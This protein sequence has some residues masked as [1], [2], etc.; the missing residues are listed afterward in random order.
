MAFSMEVV[1][2]ADVKK[3]VAEEVKP[4]PAEKTQL[5]KQAEDNAL[6][7]M[8]IDLDSLEDKKNIIQSVETFGADSVQRSAEKNNLLKTTVGQLSNAGEEG[9]VVSKGLTD[10]HHEIESLDPSAVD[11]TKTGFLGKLFNPVRGYFE[12]YEKAEDVIAN[13]MDSLDKGRATLKNDNTTLELEEQD[14]REITKKLAKGIEM[15]TMMDE[16]LQNKITEAR[17]QNMEEQKVKFVEEEILFPLRQRV[18]AMQQMT[19]VNQQGMIAME[20]IR[21]NNRELI[22]GV[23]RAKT[24][25]VSALRTAV[26]VASALYNQKIVLKKVQ[27]LNETTNNLISATSTMLKEQGAEIQRQSMQSSVSVD[28]LKQSFEDAL[29]ALDSISQYKQDALP[30][31]RDTIAQ[32]RELAEKGETEISKLERGSAAYALEDKKN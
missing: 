15:G 24:V 19:V 22:R 17:A 10:L 13:I 25:T 28:T 6:A 29:S 4:E 20:V 16:A 23:D 12:K 31:M 32:F 3:E 18:M 2:T 14:L 9:G 11:F 1:D 5:Q 30:V 7:I 27:M 21:R 8:N 26:M